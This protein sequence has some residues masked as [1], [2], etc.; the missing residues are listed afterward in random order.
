MPFAVAGSIAT[1]HLMHFPGRF[2]E[3]I[4]AEQLHQISVSFLVDDLE[5]HRGGVGA[6]IAYSMGVLGGRPLLVGA[7]GQDFDEYRTFLENNGVDC[8][9]VHISKTRHTARFTS[10]AD[11]DMCQVSSFYAGAMAEANQIELAP[12]AERVGGFD[13]VLISPDDPAAMLRHA[14][15]CRDRGYPFAVDPSQQLARL[16]G[17]Q[18]RAFID[19]ATYLFSN[20]YEWELLLSKTGWTEAEVL[21]RVGMRVTTLGDKGVQII[22]S[23]GTPVKVGS[24]PA[25]GQG[26]PTGAGDAFRGGFLTALA[27]GLSLERACQ[28][29]ALIGVLSFE[30]VGPQDWTFDRRSALRRLEDAYG[31]DVAKELGSVLPG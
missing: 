28:L 13:L 15:E 16:D 31:A 24:V 26:N 7:A 18:V 4:L 21:Q 10:T 1:D 9:A 2:A 29:G 12:I 23:D 11:D 30:T 3:Q 17:E 6:N 25:S 8:S 22:G 19:G 5:I 14:Q 27:G 20:D